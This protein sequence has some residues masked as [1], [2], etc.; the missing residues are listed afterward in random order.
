M[1]DMFDAVLVFV[2]VACVMMIVTI[3]GGMRRDE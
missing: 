1:N 3:A 2:I